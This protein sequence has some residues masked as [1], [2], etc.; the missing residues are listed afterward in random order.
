MGLIDVPFFLSARPFVETYLAWIVAS[1]ASVVAAAVAVAGLV[2]VVG[3]LLTCDYPVKTR[4]QIAMRIFVAKHETRSQGGG[5]PKPLA[6][7]IITC[8][9]YAACCCCWCCCCTVMPPALGG[10]RE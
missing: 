6:H 5:A 8:W 7:R 9:R 10:R 3:L 4:R 1:V 2:A